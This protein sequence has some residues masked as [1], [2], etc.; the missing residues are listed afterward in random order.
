MKKN[1]NEFNKFFGRNE[2]EK[3]VPSG[4]SRFPLT[5][6]ALTLVWNLHFH[7]ALFNQF[8]KKQIS[9]QNNQ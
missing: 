8:F 3:Y 5:A 9:H 6:V 2:L 4:A 7:R 1:M